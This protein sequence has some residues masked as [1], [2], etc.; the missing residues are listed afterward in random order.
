MDPLL[1]DDP[2]LVEEIKKL[3]LPSESSDDERFNKR[4]T[5]VEWAEDEG[6]ALS[7]PDDSEAL[8]PYA[9]SAPA[10]APVLSAP[11]MSPRTFLA[12]MLVGAAAAAAVFHD[13]VALILATL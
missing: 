2:A 7:P 12:L 11:T 4:R 8:S 1:L 13:R 6:I 9:P 5:L 3:D 10:P